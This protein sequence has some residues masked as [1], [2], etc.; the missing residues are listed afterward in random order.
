MIG[1]VPT[2]EML[3][4]YASGAAGEGLSLLMAAHLT[5]SP[6]SRA[7]LAEL[8]SLGGVLLGAEAGA[9]LGG[10]ALARV[11]AAID[12][13]PAPAPMDAAPVNAAPVHAAPV[14]AGPAG[15]L[16][17]PVLEALGTG[18]EQIRWG[19][20]LPGLSEVA[21]PNAEGSAISVI[22]ARPGTRI[23]QHT[24]RG[25]EYTLVL[26]GALRDGAAIYRPGD[27][28]MADHD[29]DHRPEVHGDETC[30]CLVVLEGGLRFTGRFSRALNLFQ[31]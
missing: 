4:D 11:L 12:A 19:F 15:P 1:A 25:R 10:D 22:R 21:V 17:R 8:E 14:H 27:I 24:H 13:E 18:F 7:R 26:A 29:D 23:P 5:Y 9:P 3:A 30:Y 6:A 2:D 31:G 16:P 28:D 20:R